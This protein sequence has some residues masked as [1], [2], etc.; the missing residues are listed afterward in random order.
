M[1]SPPDTPAITVAIPPYGSMRIVDESGG[2][3]LSVFAANW[4]VMWPKIRSNLEEMC[5]YSGRSEDLKAPVWMAEG[6]WLEP[7]VFMSDEADLFLSI[8]LRKA[9]VWDFFIKDNEIVH[10]QPVF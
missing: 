10:C 2:D 1:N 6:E 3:A 9:P 5:E 4:D 7:D 8:I